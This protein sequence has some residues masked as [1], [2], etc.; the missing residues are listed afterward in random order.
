MFFEPTKSLGFML[1]GVVKEY[2]WLQ[3]MFQT[4][5]FVNAKTSK[6]SD[7]ADT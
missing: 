6:Q 5:A 4:V 3:V 1:T 7:T 2:V